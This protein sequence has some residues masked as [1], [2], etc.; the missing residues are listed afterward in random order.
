MRLISTA[1]AVAALVLTGGSAQAVAT[2]TTPR[3]SANA[4]ASTWRHWCHI[5]RAGVVQQG[6]VQWFGLGDS[7]AWNNATYHNIA[8]QPVSAAGATVV[9]VGQPYQA[10]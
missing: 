9:L 6:Y 5:T 4:V 8:G 3:A 10:K 2:R 7:V 1:V